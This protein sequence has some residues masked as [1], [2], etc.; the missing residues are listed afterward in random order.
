MLQRGCDPELFNKVTLLEASKAVRDKL[1]LMHAG[2]SS[3]HNQI[4]R[5]LREK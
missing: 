4:I 2:N 5:W 1:E 3:I